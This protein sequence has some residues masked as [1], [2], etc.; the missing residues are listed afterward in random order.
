MI[1]EYLS[2]LYLQSKNRP[3]Y[4]VRELVSTRA[5]RDARREEPVPESFSRM[6]VGA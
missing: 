3:L 1:G 6:N 5:E 2:R 4:I